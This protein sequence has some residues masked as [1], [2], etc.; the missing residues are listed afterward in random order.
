L[1]IVNSHSS[2]DYVIEIIDNAYK[3]GAMKKN[4]TPGENVFV[5]DLKK[6]HG[7]YDFTVKVSSFASFYS[8][9]AGR[10]ETGKESYTDPFIC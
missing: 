2:K 9:Y 3:A 10:V 7:W 8:R 4:V 5:I 6:N 1:K